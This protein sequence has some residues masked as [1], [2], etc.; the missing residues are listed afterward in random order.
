MAHSAIVHVAE[1]IIKVN[2]E[3][4]DNIFPV[5]YF[6]PV[7]VEPRQTDLAIISVT[8]HKVMS[9]TLTYIVVTGAWRLLF[10]SFHHMSHATLLHIGKLSRVLLS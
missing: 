5:D 4:K 8:Q 6:R 7:F 1:G 10:S 9:Y 3:F 2:M